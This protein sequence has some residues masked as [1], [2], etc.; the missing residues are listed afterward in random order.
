ML[1]NIKAAF[2]RESSF[3]YD[4]N[5]K[6][7]VLILH[8]IMKIIFLL[9]ISIVHTIAQPII[10]RSNFNVSNEGQFLASVKKVEMVKFNTCNS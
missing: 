6:L 5:F 1:G 7:T 9:Q 2:V 4:A 10:W 3:R 8:T